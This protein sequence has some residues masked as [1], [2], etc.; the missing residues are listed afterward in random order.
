MVD[1]RG[2]IQYASAVRNGLVLS[3]LLDGWHLRRVNR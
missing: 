3:F 2:C 1:D